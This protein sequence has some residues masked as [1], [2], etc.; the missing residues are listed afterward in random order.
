MRLAAIVV[1]LALSSL[2]S[3]GSAYGQ[4]PPPLS[5][6]G[7]PGGECA[8]PPVEMPVGCGDLCLSYSIP[9]PS[10]GGCGGACASPEFNDQ[11]RAFGFGFRSNGTAES[12]ARALSEA[13]SFRESPPDFETG[14]A[15]LTS[16][17]GR[18]DRDFRICGSRANAPAGLWRE[19]LVQRPALLACEKAV[20]PL[21]ELREDDPEYFA[22][23][24]GG[25][26]KRGETFKT[27]F[28][29]YKDACLQPLTDYQNT[30]PFLALFGTAFA[31][32]LR[33][34]VGTLVGR[35]GGSGF[36]CTASII[37]L[38]DEP[39]KVGLL[40]AAHCVGA[41]RPMGTESSQVVDLFNPLTFTS[42]GGRTLVVNISSDVR[43]WMFPV[44]EDV[45]IIPAT[46]HLPEDI[47]GLPLGNPTTLKPFEPLYLVGINP[48]LSALVKADGDDHGESALK[49]ATITLSAPCRAIGIDRGRMVHNCETEKQMSGSPIFSLT[50]GVASIVAVHTAGDD[51]A[52]PLAACG[53]ESWV[54]INRAVLVPSR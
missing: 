33:Q 36:Q 21:M 15:G 26:V 24:G 6:V 18:V 7:C 16:A 40:T 38:S 19:A 23:L 32:Q 52:T 4:R 17:A 54:A 44:D 39:K 1:T 37:K 12:L 45:A 28:R 30:G 10:P 41:V 9:N 31:E 51:K 29:T 25:V 43:G 50:D 35:N 42:L 53:A 49:A 22:F 34:G 46:A 8:V 27:L 14:V 5:P 48:V 13:P 3:G 47:K 2:L 20:R 11:V